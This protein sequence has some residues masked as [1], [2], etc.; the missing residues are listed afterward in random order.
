MSTNFDFAKRFVPKVA[1]DLNLAEDYLCI[2]NDPHGCMLKVGAAI[3]DLVVNHIAV[4]KLSLNRFEDKASLQEYINLLE[5]TGSCPV[6]VI[7]A[8]EYIRKRRNRANHDGWN[9]EYDAFE[10]INH[11]HKILSWCMNHQLTISLFGGKNNEN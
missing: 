3:E 10:C 9:R 2:W 1:E 6:N 8:M 7:Q 11:A 4:K 5:K